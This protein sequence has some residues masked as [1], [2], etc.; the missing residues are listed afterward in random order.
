[1]KQQVTMAV[2]GN[3]RCHSAVLGENPM[4]GGKNNLISYA[5]I[6]DYDTAQ[7]VML[8]GDV[9]IDRL[10]VTGTVIVTGEV[11]ITGEEV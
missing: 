7:A 4:G 9:N 3:L 8:E 1:M 10:T 5:S 11:V 6:E 2:R